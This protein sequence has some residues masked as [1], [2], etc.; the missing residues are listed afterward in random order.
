MKRYAIR[1]ANSGKYLK[2]GHKSTKPIADS[3]KGARLFANA[4]GAKTA[5]T[6]IVKYSGWYYENRDFEIVPVVVREDL[7]REIEEYEV[8]V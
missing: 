6:N 5:C 4:G 3:I 1:D 8:T 7:D 2:H